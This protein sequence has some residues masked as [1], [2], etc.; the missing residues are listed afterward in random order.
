MAAPDGAS[1]YICLDEGPDEEGR[2]LVRDCSC[3]GD[4]AGFA[5]L[6]CIVK[7]AEQKCKQTANTGGELPMHRFSEP[8]DDCPNCKQPFKNQ[9]SLDLS[10]AFVSFAEATYGNPG[11]DAFDKINVITAL[12]SRISICIDV[13]RDNMMREAGLTTRWGRKNFDS[14]INLA[15]TTEC[16]MLCT[17]MLSMVDQVRNDL[18]MDGWVHMPRTS[19]K[20][21]LY[22]MLRLEY[23]ALGYN[24]LGIITGFD[25][26]K[27]S[28]KISIKCHEKA[29]IIYNLLGIKDKAKAMTNNIDMAKAM[30]AGG[31]DIDEDTIVENKRFSFEHYLEKHGL[32]EP[33]MRYGFYYATALMEVHRGIEAER[34]VIMLAAESRRVH[35]PEHGC[36]LWAAKLLEKC[37]TRLVYV[38]PENQPFRALRY[39]ND[40]GTC[41]VTGPITEPPSEGGERIF[42][43]ASDLIFPCKGCSV[44]CHGLVRASRLNGKVGDARACHNSIAGRRVA[45]H[46]ADKSLKTALIKPE[47]VRVAFELPREE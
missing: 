3:R 42:H 28:T 13:A 9:L 36:T 39:E 21:Q 2:P 41:V 15:Q 38:M 4:G 1:C 45:V 17:K 25:C 32:I 11:N 16:K 6:S 33:T 5:H 43:V 29:R 35:G 24:Y 18:K 26:T 34:L 27:E 46:F 12:R 20:N 31:C 37:K 8:W 30:M 14:N 22:K 19:F 7:Y 47:N 10:S 40:G 23:E 44:I